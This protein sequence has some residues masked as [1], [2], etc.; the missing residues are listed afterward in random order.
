MLFRKLM[1]TDLASTLRC[2]A[3]PSSGT[4]LHCPAFGPCNL[5]SRSQCSSGLLRC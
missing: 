3:H 2:G 5:V 4:A 1:E